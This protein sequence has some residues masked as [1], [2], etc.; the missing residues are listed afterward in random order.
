LPVAGLV[1]G[2]VACSPWASWR[3][4][5]D[6]LN[7]V[8]LLFKPDTLLR[9]HRE[10]VRRKWTFTQ[11]QR[12]KAGRPATDLQVRELLLRLAEENPTWG[13]SKLQN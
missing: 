13:Y 8:S 10:L 3:E 7:R 9:W 1:A 11:R 12:R 5:R 6:H 4:G 2:L